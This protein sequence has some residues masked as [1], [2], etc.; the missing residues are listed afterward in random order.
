MSLPGC[1]RRPAY[2][3]IKLKISLPYVDRCFKE[4]SSLRISKPYWSTRPVIGMAL[5]TFRCYKKLSIISGTSAVIWSKTIF[6]PNGRY[7]YLRST[8][9]SR[10]YTT[11]RASSILKCFLKVVF[12]EAVQHRLRFRLDHLNC[13]KMAAFLFYLQSGKYR[14][15]VLV[16]DDSHFFFV[17]NSLVKKKCWTVRC[18]D[19]TARFL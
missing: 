13:V 2:L 14:K 19:T 5:L 12:C 17:T 6:W 4:C 18:L 9:F 15:V 3:S 7:C 1:K 10:V 8:P 16:V 11:P